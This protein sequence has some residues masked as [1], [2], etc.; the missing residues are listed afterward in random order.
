MTTAEMRVCRWCGFIFEGPASRLVACCNC[1]AT[2]D[3][4]R[5]GAFS[6]G[7][8]NAKPDALL[9]AVPH[10]ATAIQELRYALASMGKELAA[11]RAKKP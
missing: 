6:I 5:G 7:V 2:N 1:G 8:S 4:R 11:L 3:S 9:L 10:M